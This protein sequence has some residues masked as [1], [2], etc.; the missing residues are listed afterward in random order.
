MKE[1]VNTHINNNYKLYE[2]LL[3]AK[4]TNYNYQLMHPPNQK[5][6]TNW[7]NSSQSELP[8]I[9]A[10]K[11]TN[12]TI[13]PTKKSVICDARSR[14]INK[15]VYS[16]I[17]AQKLKEINGN[18]TAPDDS[19]SIEINNLDKRIENKTQESDLKN[20]PNK[21]FTK[22]SKTTNFSNELKES[23]SEYEQLIK[24]VIKGY[25]KATISLLKEMEAEG[26]QN[27][28]FANQSKFS[29]L[30]NLFS[31]Y[32]KITVPESPDRDAIEIDFSQQKIWTKYIQENIRDLPYKKNFKY[33][34]PS[35][36][37]RPENIDFSNSQQKFKTD[38]SAKFLKDMIYKN[39]NKPNET[40]S[41]DI[42]RKSVFQEA[43][44]TPIDEYGSTMNDYNTN[45][46][47]NTDLLNTQQNEPNFKRYYFKEK[48]T[49]KTI[50]DKMVIVYDSNHR[51]SSLLISNLKND[52]KEF[53]LN[54]V[55]DNK[56]ES[57]QFS[58]RFVTENKNLNK[59]TKIDTNHYFS[60]VVLP[61]SGYNSPVFND[62][63]K[64]LD[65]LL[66]E[67]RK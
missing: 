7:P 44:N 13:D 37:H 46:R 2:N 36:T 21:K 25:D 63:T 29:N 66:P 65:L 27:Q 49:K 20:K 31:P 19:F 34:K 23:K 38:I 41:K 53:C 57:S 15:L 16:K 10:K 59:K 3:N 39:V 18:V 4:E 5:N 8:Q 52:N 48:N 30:S 40:F 50:N 1:T 22:G 55:E 60:H 9:P 33:T 32:K 51:D 6:F 28:N 17:E 67:I 42:F 56:N 54:N 47:S 24:K 35:F 62:K 12:E 61:T 26:E 58:T 11:Y 45:T 64:N 14:N 43:K